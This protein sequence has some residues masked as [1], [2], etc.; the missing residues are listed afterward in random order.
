ML[1]KLFTMFIL[2]AFC[3]SPAAFA[4]DMKA[5]NLSE[6]DV[7]EDN[8]QE[9]DIR[10]SVR[11]PLSTIE[12]TYN[13]L[14][15]AKTNNIL[16]Q[17]G[18]RV[19]N[20]GAGGGS[21]TGKYDSSYKL[22]IGEKI[23]VLSYGTSLDVMSMSGSNLVSPV[24][25]TEVGSNGS[26]FIPGIGPIK[27]EGRTLGEV[28]S[29][30]NSLAKSKYT[31]MSIRLQIPSGSGYS[32]FVYG[33]VAR[34]GKVYISSNSTVLDALKA[35]GG[36]KKT[37]TLRNIKYNNKTVDL[38]NTIF[39]GNDN[40]IIVKAN[41]KI[42]VDTIKKTMSFKNG[43]TNPGIYEF[44]TGETIGDLI[45]YA[46]DLQVTT[47]RT[48]IVLDG[49]D[50]NA[51]QKVAKEIDYITAK[52][53]KLTDGDS[54][55]F[56]EMYNDVE[57][58][59]TLQGNI[60]HPAVYAYKE[61]MRLSDIIKSEDELMEETFI[62]QAVIRRVSG[63]NNVVETIPVYLKD[64]FAGINDPVLQPKDIISVY[65]NTNRSF[66]DVYGCINL[67]KHIPYKDNMKLADI[68]PD[69]QFM[70]STIIKTDSEQDI[71]EKSSEETNSNKDEII[72]EG[73]KVKISATSEKVSKLI[74]AENI[75][76]EITDKDGTN[77]Q[78][79]Y[80][81]DIMINGYKIDKIKLKPEDKVFF[82]TL[83][84]NEVIKTVKISGFVKRP[85]VYSFIKGQKL[86]DIINMA[87]GLDEE[88]DLSG[89][90]FKRTNLKNRQAE[91]AR[92]NA[93]RDIKLLEGRLAAGYKQDARSQNMKLTLIE[94]LEEEKYEYG[95][96][97][98]GRIALNIKS[99][100]LDKISKVDNLDI[101]DGDDIY[102]P[103]LSTYV[104]VIGEVYNEQ[105]FIF[106]RGT[107]VK[108]YLKQVG[109]Y[110]P[111][112]NKFRIYKVGINGR[113]ERVHLSSK[114]NAGDTIIVPRRV[115]GNDWLTPIC[116]TVQ[117]LAH[118]A[119]VGLALKKW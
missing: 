38:Y 106:S 71:E 39:L 107:T 25:T 110:T 42:F 51:K 28:E 76:V 1:K 54:I 68:M 16:R 89:I 67:P 60:K 59:V 90:A 113:S 50:K 91:I 85:G 27:A 12:K 117:A 6:S 2:L 74:P 109:G 31:N 55:E 58:I 46:G 95:S 115:S 10:H 111:N 101:Q 26:I 15:N 21:A 82:R 86:T 24:T 119:I 114:V 57:N 29:E 45:K 3:T 33:E 105:A 53:T 35:A 34:P 96:M 73:E 14:E 20:S 41:D 13:S 43:V 79:Y 48:E 81:Y 98:T 64:F 4:L 97:Y 37:G 18:Y 100:D 22:S 44:K 40:G 75:A 19:F 118:T 36:V 94:Q 99:N 52:T 69:I 65:R 30:A 72:Q 66:I 108:H 56:Q 93:E 23:N 63:E 87:G 5:I 49:F 80:L 77:T 78:I 116:Q 61:G 17:A 92:Y 88:A 112:A 104:A 84:E 32:V 83:R 9:L 8:D 11:E 102:I 103:R 62:Y 7:F 47:Q 70:E